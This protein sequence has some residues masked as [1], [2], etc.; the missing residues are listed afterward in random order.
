MSV[1]VVLELGLTFDLVL[2][3]SFSI[4]ENLVTKSFFLDN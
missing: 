3:I 4:G 1:Y 2:L